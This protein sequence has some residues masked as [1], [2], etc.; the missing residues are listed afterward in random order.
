MM[1]TVTG[2]WCSKLQKRHIA[3]TNIERFRLCSCRAGR[4]LLR[5]SGQFILGISKSNSSLLFS[6]PAF[7]MERLNHAIFGSPFG[8]VGASN[9]GVVS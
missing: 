4:A 5:F 1:A 2:C 3:R 9:M 6:K 7:R 8:T